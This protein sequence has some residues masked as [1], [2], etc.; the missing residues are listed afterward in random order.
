[1][2]SARPRG[3][4]YPWLFAAGMLVV[5]LVN[6][7]MIALAVGTFPG[8]STEDA[9]RKGLA[10]NRTLAAAREQDG[11]GWRAE[12]TYAGAALT[13]HPGELRVRLTGRDGAGLP[14]LAVRALLIRPVH[15][16]TDVAV[17]LDDRGDGVYGAAVALPAAGQWDAWVHAEG[18][19]AEW[20]TT[21]R[22]VVP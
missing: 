15:G 19:G 2:A 10:Y 1:M 5:V 6:A 21:R 16:G 22:L 18:G 3:W 8:L 17:R 12:V 11:P 7:V 13:A 4:W 20:Q 9:Y 14:G